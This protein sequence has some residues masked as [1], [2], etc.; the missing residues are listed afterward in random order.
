M[1]E[2]IKRR[3][4]P[5]VLA[6]LLLGSISVAGL[7]PAVSA[8]NS[9]VPRTSGAMPMGAPPGLSA[10]P[11][12]TSVD[13]SGELPPV[14]D[15]TDIFPGSQVCQQWAS[16]YYLFTQYVKHFL[17]PEWDLNDPEH[18]FGPSFGYR[19]GGNYWALEHSGNIDMAEVPYDPTTFNL[20]TAEQAEAAKQYRISG[21]VYLWNYGQSPPL[22]LSTSDE[23]IRAAKAML[24]TGHVLDVGI[25]AFPDFPHQYGDHS[26]DT[27]YYDP[28][29]SGPST[30]GHQVNLVGYDDN[31]NLSGADADHR[32]GFLMVNC[33]GPDW[34]G[35][36]H[37]FV[38]VSYAFVK[39]YVTDCSTITSMGSDTPSISG[40]STTS[41]KAGDTIIIAGNNF[42][43]SRRASAVSF[44]GVTAMD[45]VVTNDSI[46][47]KV[48]E[49]ATSGPI[50]YY[51]WEGTPSNP[52][53]FHVDNDAWYFA[54][55]TTRPDFE[56]YFCVQ[57]PGGD[58]ADVKLTYMKTDGSTVEQKIS[59]PANSRATVH[60]ADLLMKPGSPPC[61]FSTK[62]ECT[63][64]QKIVAERPMYFNYNGS[65]TGGSDV[66][67]AGAAST[68]WFFAEGTTRT[69]FETYFC[70]QNPEA[71]TAEVKLSYL[72][73]DGTVLEQ[74]ISVP[75]NSRT[76]VHPADVILP[77]WGPADFSTVVQC[78]NDQ[79]IVA[80]RP[81]YFN[82][83]GAWT[84]GHDVMGSTAP[85]TDWYF[86][87]GTT[88]PYFE[89]YFCI[90][91][92][93][94]AAADVRLTYMKSDGS[95][96][97]Q[98]FS[99]AGLS[100][101]TVHPDSLL[102][103]AGDFSTMVEC[104][105]GQKI[106]VERPEYFNYSG[107]WTGGSDVMGA[108]MPATTFN[109]SEG[110][111]RPG[112]NTYI[113]IQN[114]GSDA[115]NVTLTY[116]KGDGTT[117][118]ETLSVA[119]NSRATVRPV[120]KLGTGNGQADDFS[121]TVTSDK[122]I[123]AERPMYFKYGGSWTGGHDVVGAQ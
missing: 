57:N 33:W 3:L 106:V 63:N 44:N 122:P 78:T 116:M 82:Y 25:R 89:T 53:F 103:G 76:T 42:G 58:P 70:I 40:C 29:P 31:I 34:N 38:W 61:D 35:D 24:A 48:P 97:E 17:H 15:Q 96:V 7:V 56:T 4:I 9:V 23:T 84:G 1:C 91:N 95:T 19:L 27:H 11:V 86:A 54:E 68:D 107:V 81:E 6:G 47:V 110:T 71:A 14:G 117:A 13:L 115:A 20:P 43:T 102:L 99:V 98:K 41:G 8:G 120:N 12:P 49:G 85:G 32:G 66:V 2:L 114:P 51:D 28:T 101:S 93:D 92:P 74:K 88:R 30:I 45:P 26:Q 62:V 65:W 5:I 36:M 80:E 123:V 83:N 79:G 73:S 67:G 60:P 59:V 21:Y 55:G 18:V 119:P 16:S 112:F 109:F 10:T 72:K 64:G 90:E 46:I 121:T 39:H 22:P 105:N 104:T 75:G 118:T 50:I 100:R 111:V 52:V 37:G 69:N 87:E 94:D 77:S 113:V 108:A